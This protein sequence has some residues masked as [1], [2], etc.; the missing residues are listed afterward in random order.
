M[1]TKTTSV[2]FGPTTTFYKNGRIIA[3]RREGGHIHLVAAYSEP[4]V[5]TRAQA[6]RYWERYFPDRACW[7]L[8]FELYAATQLPPKSSGFYNDINDELVGYEG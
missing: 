1:Y 8:P 7:D 4:T 5:L 6:Y 2:F 3:R